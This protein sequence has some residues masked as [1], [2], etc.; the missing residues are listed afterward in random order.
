MA[1][2]SNC[3]KSLFL[4]RKIE[5]MCVDCWNGFPASLTHHNRK[6]PVHE[7]FYP[8][9]NRFSSFPVSD[10][11]REGLEELYVLGMRQ[12]DLLPDLIIPPDSK[13]LNP[14]YDLWHE[15]IMNKLFEQCT[16]FGE[17]DMASR[18][19]SYSIE[20]SLY[21]RKYIKDKLLLLSA[22]EKA[23]VRISAH[24]EQHGESPKD[25][26]LKVFPD[27]EREHL[28]WAMRFYKGFSSRK[29]GNK[30]FVRISDK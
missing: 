24:L 8:L 13:S 5:G 20:K 6:L 12:F 27:I 14:K 3:G 4:K 10:I 9:N 26:I 16:R 21:Q 11:T 1:R 22:R 17:W 30:Y 7:E 2:C 19:I 28:L 25:T 18:A 15:T 23:V 29:D